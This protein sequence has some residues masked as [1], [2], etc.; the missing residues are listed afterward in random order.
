MQKARFY[1]TYLGGYILIEQRMNEK[2]PA[3]PNA[4][5]LVNEKIRFNEVLLIDENGEQL[6]VKSRVEAMN[7]AQS[8]DLDL[9]CVAPN[10][11]P[12]V[13]KILNYGKYRFEQQKKAKEM[14]K[15]KKVIDVKEIQLS[16]NIGEHD[17]N[18]KLKAARKF[19]SGGD[20]VKI[21]I[22][23]K[24]RQLAFAD[25]GVEM[26]NKFVGMCSDIAVVEKE[27][28]LEGKLLMG[29][30]APKTQKN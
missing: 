13:C 26:V 9:F 23:F 8:K 7:I 1:F 28:L 5:D 20:K 18:T 2:L 10:G 12:P 11:K 3:K 27:P 29:V 16:C 17:F 15:N 21:S 6:G 30:I 19:L 4:D 25:Q 24:G 14:R 22:R